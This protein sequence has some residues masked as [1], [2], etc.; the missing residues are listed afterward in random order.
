MAR[1]W[2][3]QGGT[4]VDWPML[5]TGCLNCAAAARRCRDEAAGITAAAAFGR[6]IA[7]FAGRE[8]TEDEREAERAKVEVFLQ[9]IPILQQQDCVMYPNPL[10]GPN[11]PEKIGDAFEWYEKMARAT[12]ICPRCST[13][14]AEAKLRQECI[15]AG[16]VILPIGVFVT[17][18][19]NQD[20]VRFR[21]KGRA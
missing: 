19:S 5:N 7:L 3:K 14:A 6:A 10:E 15:D 21:L 12:T 13:P 8:V 16:F 11:P 18:P 9:A 17:Q 2:V 1:D 4:L 20:E